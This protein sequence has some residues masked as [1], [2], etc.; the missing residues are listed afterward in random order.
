MSGP[1]YN[2]E[3]L[4]E[5]IKL[6][7]FVPTSQLTYTDAQITLLA[8]NTLQTEVV[9]LLMSCREEYF[10]DYIDQNAPADGVITFPENA[11]G[12]KLR[13]VCYVSQT[14][15][16][17]LVNLPRID[18]DVVA[19][20]GFWNFTTFAGFYI[21]GNQLMLYPANSVPVNTTIRL[22]YY[23]RSLALADPA[24]YGRVLSIDE[25]SSTVVLDQVPTAWAEDTELNSVLPTPN[26]TVTNESTTITAISSP[27]VVLSSVE[28]ISVGDYLSA[29]GY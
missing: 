16:L 29:I 24:S 8:S 20:M 13:S 27:S 22:Y 26:F 6:A 2:T 15:P 11:I 19:G 18:L 10:V 9:P 5:L 1:Q 23:R 4:I 14:N 12:E 17:V 25:G 3:N 28:G 7:C 21:Q